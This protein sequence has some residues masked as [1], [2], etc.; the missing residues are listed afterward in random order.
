M[1][2]VYEATDL[3][4][5]GRAPEFVSTSNGIAPLEVFDPID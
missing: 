2:S 1:V 3:G 4:L 5:K